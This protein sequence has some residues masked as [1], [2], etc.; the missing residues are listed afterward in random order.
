ML[1]RAADAQEPG[2]HLG[3]ILRLND[4]GT[5]PAIAD[6]TSLQYVLHLGVGDTMSI[7]T[8]G[9]EPL[10]VRFVGALSDSVLQGELA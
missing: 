7:D 6:S 1:E 9:R 5:V 3:K 4:D 10:V 8:G 2:S